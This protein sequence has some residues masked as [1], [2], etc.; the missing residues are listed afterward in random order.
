M[1]LKGTIN[2]LT[3]GGRKASVEIEIKPFSPFQWLNGPFKPETS[4]ETIEVTNVSEDL[5]LHLASVLRKELGLDKTIHP[6]QTFI[7]MSSKMN[8]PGF[9][10]NE[11]EDIIK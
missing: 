9:T 2:V 1:K 5:I 7:Q 6:H 3:Q 4:F 11:D 10:I 8:E